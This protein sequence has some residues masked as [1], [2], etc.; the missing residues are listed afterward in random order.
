[1]TYAVNRAVCA[2]CAQNMTN[3]VPFGT[4]YEL[5]VSSFTLREQS[6]APGTLR[7]PDQTGGDYAAPQKMQEGLLPSAH[8]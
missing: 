1:M 5:A 4:S 3:R 7:R 8:Q 2:G 6:G